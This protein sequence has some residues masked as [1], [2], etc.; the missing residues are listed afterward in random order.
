MKQKLDSIL[1]FNLSLS[2]CYCDIL[3]SGKGDVLEFFLVDKAS[4]STA[5]SLTC[6]LVTGTDAEEARNLKRA[7]EKPKGM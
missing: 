2:E 6:Q 5:G 4:F 1:D 3:P 7:I